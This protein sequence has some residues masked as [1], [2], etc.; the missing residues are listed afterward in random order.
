[1][2]LLIS[3][4]AAA[5][6]LVLLNRA[7]NILNDIHP[8]YAGLVADVLKAGEPYFTHDITEATGE[9]QPA[10]CIPLRIKD[11]SIGVILIYRFLMQKLEL[12]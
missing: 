4:I 3:G 5:L 11:R 6:S 10:A 12:G 9:G 8:S 1:M 2:L 7:S